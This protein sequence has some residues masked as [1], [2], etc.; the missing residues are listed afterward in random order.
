MNESEKE[1]FYKVVAVIVVVF[2][3][4]IL[5]VRLCGDVS[6][7]GGTVDSVRDSIQ[8]SQTAADE[9][10]DSIESA[11]ESN[12]DATETTERISEG[13]REIEESNSSIAGLIEQGESIL[14]SIRGTGE[15]DS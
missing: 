2:I 7:N 13:N 9:A 1:I 14:E 4:V 12:R 15:K 3:S 11:E 8:Q 6:D 10:R 5:W